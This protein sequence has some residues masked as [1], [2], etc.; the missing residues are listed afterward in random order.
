[1]E[2]ERF[3]SAAE[4]VVGGLELTR[5]I[6]ERWMAL[7]CLGRVPVSAVP[8][9]LVLMELAYLRGANWL[10]MKWESQTRDSHGFEL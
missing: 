8:A 9:G 1:M 5:S 10:K 3:L 2:E 4:E 7:L 6:A